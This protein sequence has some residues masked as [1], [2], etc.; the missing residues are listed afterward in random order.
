MASVAAAWGSVEEAGVAV[1]IGSSA[2]DLEGGG[3][4]AGTHR[5]AG[6]G[7][8]PTTSGYSMAEALFARSR[9]WNFWILPVLVLGMGSKRM[10][11]GTL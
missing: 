6:D 10:S 2:R 3:G 4:L 9:N 1:I 8:R 5:P 7:H 11:R